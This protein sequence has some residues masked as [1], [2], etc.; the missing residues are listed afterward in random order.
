MTPREV[1]RTIPVPISV[2]EQAQQFLGAG[3][4][5]GE[6]D[7]SPA[8]DDLDGWRRVIET[9]NAGIAMMFDMRVADPQPTVE[10]TSVGE[11]P[12]FVVTPDGLTDSD[13]G[14][15]Y[16]DVHG[17][18][19]TMGYGDACRAMTKLTAVQVQMRTWGVDYRTPPDH[20]YPH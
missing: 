12:V 7:P 9:A 15:V 18:A 20:R 16:L 2:S 19:F 17:G 3:L 10:T 4:G 11:V 6:N 5:M 13:P 1:V 14:G 8:I